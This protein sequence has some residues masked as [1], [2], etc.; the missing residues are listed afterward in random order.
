MRG[1]PPLGE[2][3][4]PKEAPSEEDRTD[5]L[6]ERGL[7]L[8]TGEPFPRDHL[9]QRNQGLG[10]S[11]AGAGHPNRERRGQ[12]HTRGHPTDPGQAQPRDPAS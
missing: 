5:H 8:G 9:G 12:G 7:V 6:F 4:L 2:L 1:R 11:G 10:R 3:L